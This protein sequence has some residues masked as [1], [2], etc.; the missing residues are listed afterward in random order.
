MSTFK[1]VSIGLAFLGAMTSTPALP[2]ASSPTSKWIVNFD[3]S[4]CVAIREFGTE[5]GSLTLFLKA[6]ALGDT[7]QLGVARLRESNASVKQLVSQ[8]RIND[9]PPLRSSTIAYPSDNKKL[10]LLRTNLPRTQTDLLR[11]ASMLSMRV[12]GEIDATFDLGDMMPLM[13]VLNDCVTDLRRVWNAGEGAAS[14]LKEPVSGTISGL[15]KSEDYPMLAVENGA[16]GTVEFVL[17]I[18]EQGK[19]ADCTVSETSGT[20][21]LDLKSCLIVTER[22]RF[23]PAIGLTGQPAKHAIRSRIKWVV[24]P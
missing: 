22:A 6:P 24:E 11:K 9:G 17:L 15:I 7:V 4:Q 3:A 13:S 18:D 8:I 14:V 2:K 20:A 23:K 19:V 12:E 21:V 5:K 1:F 16:S 10:R